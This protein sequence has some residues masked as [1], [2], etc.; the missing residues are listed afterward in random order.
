[1]NDEQ[2]LSIP[3]TQYVTTNTIDQHAFYLY[4]NI[5]EPSEYVGMVKD[6]R[7][8]SP[9]DLIYI[10]LN[11]DGGNLATCIQLINVMRESK[12][13]IIT[14]I[15]GHAYSAGALIFLAGHGKQVH[16]HSEIMFHSFSAGIGGKGHEMISS[17]NAMATIYASLCED[18]CSPFMSDREIQRMLKGE[19]FYFDSNEIIRRLKKV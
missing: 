9:D 14:Q 3:Y 16:K 15:D 6:I 8:A 18:V 4:G 5:G 10:Y 11:T 19:D 12:A 13:P 1:M 2:E 7:D 17:I